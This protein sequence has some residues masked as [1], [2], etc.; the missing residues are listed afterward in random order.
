MKQIQKLPQTTKIKYFVQSWVRF[1][2]NKYICPLS[3]L[4]TCCATQYTTRGNGITIKFSLLTFF[5]FLD[6]GPYTCEDRSCGWG[7]YEKDED[8]G[9]YSEREGD[10]LA[11][12]SECSNDSNCWAVECGTT[13]CSWWIIGKCKGDERTPGGYTT[14]QKN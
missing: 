12:Q 14:C 10:C 7:S 3:H 2:K 13:Y 5:L 9:Y 4:K 1:S 6:T 11:C 8:Y